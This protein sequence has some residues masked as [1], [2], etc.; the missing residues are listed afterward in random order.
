[1]VSKIS[2]SFLF[3][4]FL[5]SGFLLQ[6][7]NGE[8][9]FKSKCAACHKTSSKKSIG[10]GLANVHE[11]YSKEWFKK[12]V[13]SS[14]TLIKSGDA[15]AIKIFEEYNKV[16]MPDQGLSDAELNTIFDYIKSVNPAKTEVAATETVE[17]KVVPFEPTKEDILVGQNLFSGKQI[18]K[19]GG[20]SCV[21]CHDIRYDAV[22]AGGG[23]SVELT[24][25]YDRLKKEGVEGMITGL[26]FPQMRASY[27]NHQITEEETTQLTAFL[28]EV[29]EQRYY[30]LGLTSYKNVLLIWGIIG[31]LMLMGIFPLFWY[32]RKKESV[33]KRIYERQIKSRN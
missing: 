12:F 24:D 5:F 33:N 2:T 28:K 16:V 1:M 8:S 20:P 11:K 31:T 32:K 13:N 14:Q 10:P 17:E 22:T 4:S 9:L 27:Q 21:S 18:F 25:V 29:S 26:P 3:I 19:N 6:A 15:D 7:Q 23:L 30:Q